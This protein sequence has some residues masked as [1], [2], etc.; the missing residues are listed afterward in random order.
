MTGACDHDGWLVFDEH[1]STIASGKA[2]GDEG[3]RMADAVIRAMGV[4]LR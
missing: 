3:E 1:G 4:T 2:D